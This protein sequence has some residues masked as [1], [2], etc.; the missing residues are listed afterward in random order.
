MK[1][2]PLALAAVLALSACEKTPPKEPMLEDYKTMQGL[3][4]TPKGIMRLVDENRDG[5]VDIFFP[6]HESFV[7]YIAEGHKTQYQTLASTQTV[8]ADE[9]EL[10]SQILKL[11]RE[12]RYKMEKEEYEGRERN[13]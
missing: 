9:R 5:T 2:K 3:A 13:S 11:Q 6:Q 7:W 1:L 12:L 4:Q 8:T 10:A